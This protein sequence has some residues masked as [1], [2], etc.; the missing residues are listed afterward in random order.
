M[1]GGR[2][3][4]FELRHWRPPARPKSILISDSLLI[5]PLTTP[6]PSANGGYTSLAELIPSHSSD[7]PA[8]N[9]PSASEIQIRNRLL[10]H[11]AYAYLQPA[12]SSTEAR[13][14]R[15]RCSLRRVL[16]AFRS[17]FRWLLT[18]IR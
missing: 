7:S 11:A 5:N 14:S 4:D 9:S 6:P 10:Q 18:L 8:V 15:R 17:C 3:G 16:A 13:R 2:G 12:P 1:G